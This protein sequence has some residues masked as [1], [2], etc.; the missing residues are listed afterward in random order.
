MRTMMPPGMGKCRVTGRNSTNYGLARR[1][2]FVA[3]A[4]G[5]CARHYHLL[6]EFMLTHP[7]VAAIL[8]AI[9]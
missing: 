3:T 4:G 9:D 7:E 2:Q 1:D 6:R 8:G 5:L